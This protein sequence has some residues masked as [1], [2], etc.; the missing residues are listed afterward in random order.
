MDMYF[1]CD[2]FWG[3]L[4]HYTSRRHR[5]VSKIIQGIVHYHPLTIQPH[6]YYNN[7]NNHNSIMMNVH[8]NQKYN[9]I[10]KEKGM[11]HS[12]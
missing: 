7:N 2:W 10:K 1:F 4:V 3:T 11:T 12:A 6:Y 8:L 9:N 5:P